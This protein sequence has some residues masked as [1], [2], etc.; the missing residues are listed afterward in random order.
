[1]KIKY[2]IISVISLA[3]L[4]YTNCVAGGEKEIPNT[5]RDRTKSKIQFRDLKHQSTSGINT[6]NN[7]KISSNSS[8]KISQ[9]NYAA[10]I[11][12]DPQA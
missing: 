10:I 2:K 4:S 1:M 9:K 3:I 5:P 6:D 11:M 8:K 7:A 12:S